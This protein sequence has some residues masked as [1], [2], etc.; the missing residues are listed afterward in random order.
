MSTLFDSLTNEQDKLIYMGCLIYSKGKDNALIVQGSKDIKK[1]I[2]KE[3][4]TKSDNEDESLKPIDEGSMKKVMKK[5]STSKCFYCSKGFHPKNKC[6]KNNMH[7]MSQF[8]E[9]HNIEVPYEL[10]KLVD[11]SQHYHSA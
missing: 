7:I 5:G 8:L 11:S 10:E 3:K 1:K 6:F 9:K 4:K 2:V